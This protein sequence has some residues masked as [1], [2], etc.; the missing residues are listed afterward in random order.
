MAALVRDLRSAR[1]ARGLSQVAVADAIGTS[2]QLISQWER[3]TGAPRFTRAAA[4]GAAVG[5]DV[6]L[7][8]FPGAP[9]LRDAGQLRVLGR[10]QQLIGSSWTWRT[11]APVSSAPLDRRAIDAVISRGSIRIGLEVIT[12][13]ADAQ[14]QVRSATLKQ[15][16]ARLDRMILVLA[17]TRHNR[18]ALRAATPTLQPA[19]PVRARALLWALRAGHLPLGNGVLLV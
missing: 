11:E 18:A 3:G 17:K 6:T 13:L 12:R 5:L 15:E 8:S 4:W 10:A 2:H 14:A 1:L 9:A 7:R 16:T 19:F